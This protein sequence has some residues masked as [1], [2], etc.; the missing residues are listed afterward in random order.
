[1]DVC[2]KYPH[3]TQVSLDSMVQMG[4][5]AT[6]QLPTDVTFLFE[7]ELLRNGDPIAMITDEMDYRAVGTSGINGRHMNFPNFPLVDDSPDLGMNTYVL[8]CTNSSNQP[9]PLITI[10]SRSLKATVFEC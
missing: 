2:V 4:A 3:K 5:Q 9:S 1:M 8:R 6:L 7:Y 10:G